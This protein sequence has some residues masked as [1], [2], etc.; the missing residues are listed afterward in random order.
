MFVSMYV[1]LSLKAGTIETKDEWIVQLREIIQRQTS[2]PGLQCA[3]EELLR[4]P[5]DTMSIQRYLFAV[6]YT[7][8]TLPTILRV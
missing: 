6:S 3:G 8:L 7:H 5:T 1:W 2:Q 4:T